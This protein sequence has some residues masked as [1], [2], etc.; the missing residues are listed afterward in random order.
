[1]LCIFAPHGAAFFPL[2]KREIMFL[3]IRHKNRKLKHTKFMKSTP[4]T[5]GDGVRLALES[6][7]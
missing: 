7:L 5:G 6:D 4:A 1:L 3:K 2:K